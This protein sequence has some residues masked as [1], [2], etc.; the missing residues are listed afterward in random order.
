MQRGK[1]DEALEGQTDRDL[2]EIPP[3]KAN[4][5]LNYDY[6]QKNSARLELVA[7]DRWDAFDEDNGEQEL[8]GY[9]VLNFKLTHMVT[10]K[11]EVTAGIDN[12][13]DKTYAVSNTYNDLT[14]IS[15]GA[16]DEVMLLNEPGR[17]FYLNTTYRF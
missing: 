7:A 5:A 17:Y 11:F 14:L 3:L 12:L 1:K 16:T 8:A 4:L 10:S 13:L 2:A 15:S 9:G 6:G